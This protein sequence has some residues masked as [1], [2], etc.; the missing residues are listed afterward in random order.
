LPSSIIDGAAQ[1]ESVRSCIIE[2]CLSLIHFTLFGHFATFY[3]LPFNVL[4]KQM[5]HEEFVSLITNM[6]RMKERFWPD[7]KDHLAA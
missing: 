2:C 3:Y 5:M 6:D 1:R 7:W 4:L